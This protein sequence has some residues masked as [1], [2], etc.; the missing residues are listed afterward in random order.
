MTGVGNV[1]RK[2]E[3]IGVIKYVVPRISKDSGFHNGFGM[4]FISPPIN[5]I[6]KV[7]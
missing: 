2:H 3:V 4:T 7:T 5:I 6:N 1:L